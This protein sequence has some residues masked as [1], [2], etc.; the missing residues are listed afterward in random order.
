MR[1]ARAIMAQTKMRG[2]ATTSGETMPREMRVHDVAARDQRGPLSRRWPRSP[3]HT[4]MVSARAPTARS[5]IVGYV[6]RADVQRH[7]AADGGRKDDYR[8]R[9]SSTA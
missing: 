7:V 4:P 2:S 9:G 3:A 5:D 6:V 1:P 8:R